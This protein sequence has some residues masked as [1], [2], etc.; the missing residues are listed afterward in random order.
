MSYK[1]RLAHISVLLS[2]PIL[3]IAVS[4]LDGGA[5]PSTRS[6]AC[7]TVPYPTSS[8][9]TTPSPITQ[10]PQVWSFVSEPK[11]H[12]MK[13]AISTNRPGTS[14]GLIFVAPYGFSSEAQYGQSGSLMLD[15]DG[16][17]LWFRPLSS[18]N[19]MNTDFRIQTLNG[20]PVLT[21]WQGTLATSPAYLNSPAGSSEPGSCYY[22]LDST[23]R[24]I[25][26]V[27][28]QFGFISDV[29]EFLITPAN[30][31]L[32]LSTRAIPMNLGPYGGPAKGYVQDFAVQE[33]DLQTNNVLF[34]WDAL[35][36]IPLTDSYEPASSATSSG[37]VWDVYHLNSIS[38][39][40]SPT[41]ILVSSRNTWTIYRINKPTGS[42]VWR[43]GGKQSGFTV[44]SGAAFSWQHDARFLP[45]NVVSLFDDNCCESESVPP[46]T[47]PS[48]G[49]FLQLDLVNMTAGAMK[50]Y[51][52][53]PNLNVASQ[54]NTQSLTDGNVFVGW[55]QGAYYSEFAPAGNSVDNPGM[56]LLY[57]AQLATNNY[58]YR[59]YREDWVGTPYYPPSIS[60]AS[61]SG[62]TTVY[63]SWNGATEVRTWEVFGG[64][65][66]R[67]LVPVTSA[68]KSGFETS[69]PVASTAGPFFQVRALNS[70]GEVIG[71]S[72]TMRVW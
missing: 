16:N 2:T 26:T 3:A 44:E 13:V 15:N 20:T 68:A 38:L 59:T 18:P 65:N 57:D 45:N 55:G 72:A 71:V 21:F 69:I 31:A 34:F 61:K 54:G 19:L 40:D 30:T 8:G 37:D 49:L 12:P 46:G 62:S 5:A 52:H 6:A 23:Y 27:A 25:K 41:D 64:R 39:T 70:A 9:Y 63:A 22:I 51:Y 1:K 14:D 7:G 35:K 53:D 58:S 42:I 36:N 4:G 17:P 67:A 11:L 47:P 56:N 10:S 50:E 33:I 43:L 32:L 60:V 28:A 29:H 48:H 66:A 24:V